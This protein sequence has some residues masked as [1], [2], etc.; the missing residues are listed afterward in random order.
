MDYGI[1]NKRALV[2]GASGG[3]GAA[4]A[5]ALV[6]EGVTVYGAARN[7]DKLEGFKTELGASGDR[8]IPVTLDLTDMAAVDAVAARLNAEGGID[9]LVNNTGG[10]APG[11]A[12]GQSTEAWSKAFNLLALPVFR[13]TDLLL[14][15]MIAQNWGRIISIGSSGIEAPIPNLALSNGAR[16]AV[17]GWSKTLAGEVA[18]HGVTVNMILPGRIATDRV[19]QLDQNAASRE[20]LD[21]ETVQARSRATIPAGRYG[22]PEEFGAVCAFLASTAASY[23]TGSMI[24]V[25]GGMIRSV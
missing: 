21:V 18:K 24:R 14:P 5:A 13:L 2:L 1:S 16:A 17:A 11:G 10:P 12:H 8:F 23:V 6:A 3:L 22:R 7:T 20:S 9:I 15:H 4:C 19:A 25:D